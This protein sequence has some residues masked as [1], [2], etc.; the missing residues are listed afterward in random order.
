M[1]FLHSPAQSDSQNGWVIQGSVQSDDVTDP[2]F[3]LVSNT[4]TDRAP[5]FFRAIPYGGP[6]ITMGGANAGDTVGNTVDLFVHISDLSGSTNE[7]FS[8]DVDGTSARYTITPARG[9]DVGEIQ[10]Q[11]PYNP[12]GSHSVNVSALASARTYNTNNPPVDAHLLFPSTVS[13]PLD[14]ENAAFVAWQSDECSPDV[15]TNYIL[16]GLEQGGPISATISDPANGAIVASYSGSVPS[17]AIVELAWNFT[18]AD[19]VTP[20]SNDTYVVA[21]NAPTNAPLVV[22]NKISRTGVRLAEGCLVSY[23][24][25]NP[26]G[27]S[28]QAYLDDRANLWINN[29]LEPIYEALY[30]ADFGSATAYTVGQIGP[31]RDN[32]PGLFPL[33]L[34]GG[35]PAEAYFYTNL[36]I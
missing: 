23:E 33:I 3:M 18:E 32:R 21:F 15:G 2:M 10:I 22:T 29:S 30:S 1:D 25:E 27:T 8:V 5:S 24:K 11:T 6:V 17:P 20:Y 13:M 9:S 35:P 19:G 14:F 12:N 34:D 7:Q 28:T 16:F 31:F 26:A 36:L 4:A